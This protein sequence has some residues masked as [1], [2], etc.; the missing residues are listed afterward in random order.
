M[1]K[2]LNDDLLPS[3]K[4]G[5]RLFW[6]LEV[7]LI[8]WAINVIG[9]QS[10]GKGLGGMETQQISLSD[11]DKK[12]LPH[13]LRWMDYIQS[14]HD[15]EE[16][17]KWIE[18]EKVTFNLPGIC[19]LTDPVKPGSVL[20]G[21]LENTTNKNLSNCKLEVC[22]MELIHPPEYCNVNSTLSFALQGIDSGLRHIIVGADYGSVRIGAFMGGKMITSTASDIS[23]QS[24]SNGIGNNL[25]ELEEFEAYSFNLPDTLSG[26]ACLT[27][28]D[29]HNGPLTVI[30]KKSS[31]AFKALLT[32]VSSEEK[33]TALGELMYKC[34]K[35]YSACGLGSDGIDR[36]VQL[37]QEMHHRE[38]FVSETDIIVQ[39][40]QE[41]QHIK[42]SVSRDG[43]LYWAKIMGGGFGGTIYV[44][45]RN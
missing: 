28:Y 44:I 35:S 22:P 13:L 8:I 3:S 45:D 25:D 29:H 1:G 5:I 36:L 2:E 30:D 20:R 9:R 24:Y 41:T 11:S 19:H 40:V 16:L 31:Y 38:P 7:M 32:S 37:V 27:K 33:P 15:L 42:P 18:L 6:L 17:F 43:T 34:H 12:K 26:E 4:M 23:S 14:T 21:P 39:L 10:G